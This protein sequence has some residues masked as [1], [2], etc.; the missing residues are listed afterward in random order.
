MPTQMAA[1]E[2][3]RRLLSRFGAIEKKA[4]S[5]NPFAYEPEGRVFE[6]LQAHHSNTYPV[7]AVRC[8]GLFVQS[9]I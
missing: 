7:I 8:H 9:S 5:P 1:N 2:P 3:K 4:P 6:S